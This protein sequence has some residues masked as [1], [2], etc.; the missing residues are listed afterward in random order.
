MKEILIVLF[1]S[2]IYLN[3]QTV[4]I[5]E[6][7]SK[8]DSTIQD[9]D[10]DFNDWIELHNTTS[11][12]VNLLGYNLSDDNNN[13]NKWTFPEVTI[14][15]HNYLLL[16]ASG[17]NRL[18]TTEL[19][20]NFKISSGGEALYLSN[21]SGTIIDQTN[22]VNLSSDESYARIIDGDPRWLRTNTPTPNSSNT[23]STGVYNAYSSG[24][25][26][27]SFQL[28]LIKLNENQQIYYT[29]N[30]SIP[31]ANSNLYTSPVN[32][33]NNSKTPYSI[34]GIPT[35]PQSGPEEL[36]DFIWHE[37]N[38]VYKCNVIRYAAFDGVNRQSEIY[39]KTYFIDPEV[40]TKYEFPIISL[41]TDSLHLFDYDSGIYIPG[42]RFDD[43]DW[44][45]T[46]QGNYLYSGDEWERDVHIS[47]FNN[48]GGALNFESD[49][50]MRMRG[51][52]SLRYPQK[53]FT[54][55]FRSEY[56]M[57]ELAYSMLNN[58]NVA[59]YKR[60]V[61]RNSGNDFP[62]T[63]F[64]D[65]MLQEIINNM[66]LE[67]QD[68]QPSITFINGEYWGIYNLRE[69]YDR[70]Y[71][72]YKYGVPEDSINVLGICGDVE[73][74]TN[75]DYVSL[76]D[77]VVQNDLSTDQNYSFVSQ[78]IDINNFIDYQIA[79]IYFANDDWPCSNYKLWKD[80]SPDSKWRFLIYDLD[81]SFNIGD[82]CSPSTQSMERATMINPWPTCE[83]SNL[84]FRKLLLNDT[85]K[86]Q[87]L[88]KFAFHLKHTFNEGRINLIID[89][90][91]SLYENEIEDHID[92]WSYPDSRNSWEHEI[93]NLRIF[94]K[95]R[96]CYMTEN[97]KLFFDLQDDEFDF[98]CVQDD[99]INN[100][101]VFPN[102]NKGNFSLLNTSNINVEN[103]TITLTNINGQEI[104]R[105]GRID[106]EKKE[107]KYFNLF[108]LT[109]SIYILNIL[110]P[111]YSEQIKIIISK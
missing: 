62:S 98:E 40:N 88:N 106:L 100:I 6:F 28:E 8:N 95:E 45:L 36:Y 13:L 61:F 33:N 15:P 26:D 93:E 22:A 86:E 81:Q 25:Y 53:S 10:N 12:A 20:T 52:S 63:H 41:I 3:G 72:K 90:F 83:C 17:K 71:F 91:E 18:D 69:Q 35:T 7:M 102:P 44:T 75:L 111:N 105:E 104:Y 5:N 68:F 101:I 46:P 79:Q 24:F 21:N 11:S 74:G 96:P 55:Y 66:D 85:F 76:Y 64:R 82:H 4:V 89:E 30:G 57:S 56:G 29:L 16:F 39:S 14:L 50:G 70:Y 27:N 73:E 34:S 108:N 107:S 38:S 48:E 99:L 97:I 31:T 9:E 78:Q 103:V 47:Y 23:F 92:R 80:N 51:Y 58:P 54:V 67:K 60:I 43:N 42:K 1:L 77:F 109:P 19:H 32:I 110:S 49:A 37:P 94:A 84:I 59:K 2:T 65:A 87:F